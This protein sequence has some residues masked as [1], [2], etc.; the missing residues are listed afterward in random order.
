MPQFI[1]RDGEIPLTHLDDFEEAGIRLERDKKYVFDIP[2]LDDFKSDSQIDNFCQTSI[3]EFTQAAQKDALR[4]L[5]KFGVPKFETLPLTLDDSPE[6][7]DIINLACG[8]IPIE[9]EENRSIPAGVYAASRVIEELYRTSFSEE[10]ISI[11]SAYSLAMVTQF[12]L[13]DIDFLK[14]DFKNQFSQLQSNA[15]KQKRGSEGPLKSAIRKLEVSN[16]DDLLSAFEDSECI[17]DFFYKPDEPI[18]IHEIEIYKE[19][20]YISYRN[21][22]NKKKTAKFKTLRNILTDINN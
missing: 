14:K 8:I 12:V 21:R 4:I 11:Q 13:G 20:E 5:N 19:E 3:S 7:Q 6:N 1:L 22:K 10:Q 2:M 18:D 17:E 16:L 15:A 9:I